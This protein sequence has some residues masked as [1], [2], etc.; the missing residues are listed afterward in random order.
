MKTTF[1]MSFSRVSADGRPTGSKLTCAVYAMVRNA[2]T[3][4]AARGRG[5]MGAFA[6]MSGSSA[7]SRET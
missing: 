4:S 3:A 2:R 6:S 5:E 7:G 1:V